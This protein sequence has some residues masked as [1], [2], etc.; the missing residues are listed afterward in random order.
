MIQCGFQVFL[1]V[2][3]ISLNQEREMSPTMRT[4]LMTGTQKQVMVTWLIPMKI[5]TGSEACIQVILIY[6][7]VVNSIISNFIIF[8]H[9]HITPHRHCLTCTIY[10]SL[11][12]FMLLFLRVRSSCEDFGYR[13]LISY[14]KLLVNARP[15]HHIFITYLLPLKLTTCGSAS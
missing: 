4:T 12:W 9:H 15:S 5:Y 7:S 2:C 11:T 8:L 6:D 14:I 10:A 13:L 3:N 1:Q